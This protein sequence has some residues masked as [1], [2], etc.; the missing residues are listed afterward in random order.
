[1]LGRVEN[2][3]YLR[4][5]TLEDTSNVVTWRNSEA[6]RSRFIY[7][8]LF[9]VES[10]LKW[11]ETMVDTGKVVQTII[12]DAKTDKPLGSVYIRDIDLT[13]NKGEYGI[14]IGEE[15]AR[16]KGVG[17]TAAK[18]MVEHAFEDMKLHRLYLRVFADNTQAIR[19]YEKAGFQKEAHLKDDVYIDNTYHDI[20]L[21]AIVRKEV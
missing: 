5:M 7:R 19:S 4:A 12:C 15:E 2:G 6:V 10:H 8:E 14:F 21:M 16:G 20:V 18:L 17:T 11:V 9:T 3:I 1:M 13:H